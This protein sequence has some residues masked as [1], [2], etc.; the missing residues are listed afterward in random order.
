MTQATLSMFANSLDR[1]LSACTAQSACKYLHGS[2]SE[3]IVEKVRL[4]ESVCLQKKITAAGYVFAQN[5]P[6]CTRGSFFVEIGLFLHTSSI[7]KICSWLLRQKWAF[8]SKN[9][10]M[11]E[12]SSQRTA[13]SKHGRDGRRSMLSAKSSLRRL[14]R[15]C[16]IHVVT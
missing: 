7:V 14:V 8:L 13:Q 5:R 6:F 3:R 12:K 15:L 9:R 16:W 4:Y 2:S 10:K 11:S 1:C